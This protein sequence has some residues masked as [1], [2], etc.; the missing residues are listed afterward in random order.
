MSKSIVTFSGDRFSLDNPNF[1]IVDIA[2]ALSMNCRF[3]GHLKSFYSVAQHS[4]I[5]CEVA[6]K[7]DE[8][9]A[10]LH[11][12]HE[13]Y[14]TDMPWPFKDKAP[15][16]KELQDAIDSKLYDYFGVDNPYTE[17][18]KKI[19]IRL[20]L[21]EARDLMM[22]KDIYKTFCAYKD[23]YRPYPFEIEPM[24]PIQAESQFLDYYR[25]ADA[26]KVIC[27]KINK[28]YIE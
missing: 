21:T 15:G 17:A 20:G 26:D 7:E 8:L 3:N 12:A 24:D 6:R 13:A 25:E 5:A 27:G 16:I 1:S 4:C 2:H 28:R 22:N 10:L 23:G 19:D 11:D 18:I 9:K 14:T